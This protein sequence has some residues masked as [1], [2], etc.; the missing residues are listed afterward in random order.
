MAATMKQFLKEVAV[1]LKP[2]G[3][4]YAH[5]RSEYKEAVERLALRKMPAATESDRRKFVMFA[6]KLYDGAKMLER[7]A[8]SR[9]L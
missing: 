4:M 1:L 9:S 3:E 7:G 2:L 6:L 8:I 5:S